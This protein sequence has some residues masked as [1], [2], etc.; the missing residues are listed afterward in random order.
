MSFVVSSTINGPQIADRLNKNKLGLDLSGVDLSGGKPGDEISFKL[1]LRMN[2]PATSTFWIRRL[3]MHLESSSN[4]TGSRSG[5]EDKS[6]ALSLG[7]IS[8]GLSF[9]APQDSTWTHFNSSNFNSALDRYIFESKYMYGY[10]TTGSSEIEACAPIK[11][12]NSQLGVTTAVQISSWNAGTKTVTIP[13]PNFTDEM[14]GLK[15]I[16]QNN[17]NFGIIVSHTGTTATL[18]R[19]PTGWATNDYLIVYG[20]LHPLDGCLAYVGEGLEYGDQV[21]IDF[22]FKLPSDYSVDNIKQFSLVFT[23]ESASS[24]TDPSYVF[25]H[26]PF[27]GPAGKSELAI[28]HQ[29]LN[30][31]RHS[32]YI[33]NEFISDNHL[34]WVG[35]TEKPGDFSVNNLGYIGDS[36]SQGKTKRYESTIS[37]T[38]HS[39]SY[40]NLTKYPNGIFPTLVYIGNHNLNAGDIVKVKGTSSDLLT[41]Y[42][43]VTTELISTDDVFIPI[44]VPLRKTAS[45]VIEFELQVANTLS[46]GRLILSNNLPTIPQNNMQN[47]HRYGHFHDRIETITEA[48]SRLFNE[49][50]FVK[51]LEISILVNKFTQKSLDLW[52]QKMI[53]E[54]TG[55]RTVLIVPDLKQPNNKSIF[56]IIE[57]TPSFE[58]EELGWGTYQLTLREPL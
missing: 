55:N 28:E 49:K 19:A 10:L 30:L 12:N 35:N 39:V 56:G 42:W 4:Y 9:K 29:Y 8:A 11:I 25:A 45:V 51:R 27:V 22:K 36:D 46:I 3:G 7:D 52:L 15:L 17:Q 1:F 18:D 2:E 5:F 40:G 32:I 53:T 16:N 13:L 31:S 47:E 57:G 24:T 58:E 50:G 34:G 20:I 44:F 33:S 41:T 38:S 6:S 48:K 37:S 26:L 54:G 43:E 14:I 21:E 23:W